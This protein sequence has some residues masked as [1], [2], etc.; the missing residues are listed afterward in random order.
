VRFL[1][2]YPTPTHVVVQLS[3]THIVPAGSVLHGA[4]DSL[5]NVAAVFDQMEAAGTAVTAVVFTGDLAD[6]GDLASYQRLRELV[7]RRAGEL[8]LPI[9]Y[10][11]GNH[12]SRGP[13]REGLL[14][15]EPTTEPYDH[16]RWFDGLR[17]VALDSTE[18]GEALG[19]LSGAQLDWLAAEL[20]TP[21]PAGTILALH[22]PPVPSP[23]GLLNS[24]VLEAPERLAKVVADS[25]VKII[26]SGHAHHAS[27]GMLGGIPVWVAGAT[28][29]TANAMGPAGGYSGVTGGQFSRIDVFADQAVVTSLPVTV[30]DKLY[31][32]TPEMLARYAEENDPAAA[33]HD[34]LQH[35]TEA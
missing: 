8:G 20:A 17:I 25:D 28:A 24:L 1:T 11:V 16:V 33:T 10:L 13:L 32:L 14:G 26:I 19:E 18:P 31:E 15:V 5:A 6:A 23:I 9:V 27:A 2:D 3:D 7:S 4:V 22:H 35:L 29:Y 12:D 21:A 30:G 34:D